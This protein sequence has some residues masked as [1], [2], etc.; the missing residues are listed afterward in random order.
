VGMKPNSEWRMF[1]S[2]SFRNSHICRSSLRNKS[3]KNEKQGNSPELKDFFQLT[4]TDKEC[5]IKEEVS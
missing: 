1:R 4:C 2:Q 3:Y 5:L